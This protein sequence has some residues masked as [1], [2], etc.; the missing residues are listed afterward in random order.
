MSGH[1]EPLFSAAYDGELSP[2]ARGAFD[3]HLAECSACATAYAELTTAV[4]ALREQ[5]AARMPHPVRLP[6][7]SPVPERRWFGVP[8]PLP[9]GRRLLAGLTAVGVVA[10]AGVAAALVITGGSLTRGPEH[11]VS[12]GAALPAAGAPSYAELAPQSS[13]CS[14]GCS[15]LP[16]VVGPS[17]APL[18]YCASTSL[19]VSATSAAQIPDGF[20]NRATQD[21][22]ITD[23]ILATPSLD[24]TP[25]ETVDV[26]VRLIDVSSGAVSLPCTSLAGPSAGGSG[27]VAAVPGTTT[28]ATPVGTLT[29][30]GQ[31]V[32]EVVVPDDAVAGDTYQI[33]AEVPAGAGEAQTKQVTLSIQVT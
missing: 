22:G 33:V 16:N 15:V 32:L 29:V 20:N 5:P 27:T 9:E 26:Y 4:D 28:Y 24:Y 31:P 6:E 23:V 3:R 12:S 17:S 13:A 1:V 18:G 21:D 19:S 14:A 8:A 10:A 11:G 7:G 2:D 30:S 25:G